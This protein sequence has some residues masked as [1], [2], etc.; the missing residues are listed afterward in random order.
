M[1]TSPLAWVVYVLSVSSVVVAAVTWPIM[2]KGAI[3][4][5]QRQIRAELDE[6]GY[7][8]PERG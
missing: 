2:R 7:G 8:M 4:A 5:R 6:R 1:L 3:A